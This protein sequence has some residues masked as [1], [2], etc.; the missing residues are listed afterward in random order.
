MYQQSPSWQEPGVQP[1][2]SPASE[3]AGYTV[4]PSGSN[5][6]ECWKA[7]RTAESLAALK[8][9]SAQVPTK[10]K[11]LRRAR[12]SGPS[13]ETLGCSQDP[14]MAFFGWSGSLRSFVQT[15]A[16]WQLA[17]CL[18]PPGPCFLLLPDPLQHGGFQNPTSSRAQGAPTWCISSGRLL[19]RLLIREE[20][21]WP[22]LRT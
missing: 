19:H 11:S 14:Q 9:F 7:Q 4:P 16:S 2:A 5:M 12:T 8:P 1:D 22:L 17:H 15:L 13:L 18:P 21:N 20:G 6:K 10:F 3:F